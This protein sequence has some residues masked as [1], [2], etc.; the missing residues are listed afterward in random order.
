MKKYVL[1]ERHNEKHAFNPDSASNFTDNSTALEMVKKYAA[2][3]LNG[4]YGDTAKVKANQALDQMRVEG[5]GFI[6]T[7]THELRLYSIDTA[8]WDLKQFDF[9]EAG[10]EIDDG[11]S[12][13][14]L[15]NA[16]IVDVLAYVDDPQ[17][18]PI[19]E[20]KVKFRLHVDSGDKSYIAIIDEETPAAY[21]SATS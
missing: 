7:E 1:V 12:D 5:S 21:S 17:A 9:D 15:D 16:E 3:T 6:K 14:D 8:G 13:I 19:T 2:D 18:M 4:K 20:R 10:A 11:P